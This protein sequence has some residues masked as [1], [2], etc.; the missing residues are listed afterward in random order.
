MMM[1]GE[2]N[3][4]NLHRRTRLPSKYNK[5]ES[6]IV[7]DFAS[8]FIP[9]AKPIFLSGAGTKPFL[10]DETVIAKLGLSVS[11]HGKFPDVI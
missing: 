4:G 10:F 8:R 11:E 9:G 2:Y 7:E 1:R 5:L 3:F 6:V